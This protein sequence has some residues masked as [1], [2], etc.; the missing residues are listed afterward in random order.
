MGRYIYADQVGVTTG[1]EFVH[2]FWFGL[3]SNVSDYLDTYKNGPDFLLAN[4][5]IDQEAAITAKVAE[6]EEQFEKKYGTSYERFRE[7]AV[8]EHTMYPTAGKLA[9]RINLGEHLLAT[10]ANMK[11]AGIRQ[12]QLTIDC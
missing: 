8:A 9:N 6:L 2:Q 4:L 5:S 10:I 7:E 3:S 11:A 1:D 12:Q